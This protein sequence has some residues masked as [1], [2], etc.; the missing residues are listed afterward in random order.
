MDVEKFDYELPDE[1]IAQEPAQ[2]RDESRLLVMKRDGDIVDHTH[3]NKLPRLL[4]RGDRLIL[5]DSKVI[6]ARLYG[7]KVSSGIEIEILLLNELDRNRGDCWEVLVNP[8]R[9]VKTGTKINFEDEIEAECLETTDFGGRVLRFSPGGRLSEKLE[10]LGE[11]PLPPYIEKEPENPDRY[12]TVYAREEGSV[13][14]PTAGLHFT[15]DLL[16]ELEKKGIQT[17]FIT[18]HVGLGTFRPVRTEKVEDHDMH[19][20]YYEVERKTARNIAE[21]LSSEDRIVAVGTTVT[22]TLEAA[23]ED[24]IQGKRSQGWT[25]LFIYPGY[26]FKIIDS[27]ITNFH[28]PESTLIMLV[29]ALAG[30]ENVLS[31]YREA[32]EKKYRFYSFGDAMLII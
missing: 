1:L 30:R 14:A 10:E 9:R 20:E 26:D 6:P 17:S 29:S 5:N 13:A 27:L 3:F 12:Q 8:G 22:R 16:E 28:L 25:D 23:A 7:Q 11:M 24:I 19:A 2:R 18:L 21:T 15:D 4:S 31:A 32:I